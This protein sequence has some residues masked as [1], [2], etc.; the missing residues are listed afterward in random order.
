M[1][2]T[3][4]NTPK[5]SPRDVWGAELK[6]VLTEAGSSEPLVT[7]TVFDGSE[8]PADIVWW[9]AAGSPVIYIG[10]GTENAGSLP[11][12]FADLLTQTWGPGEVTPESPADIVEWALW[13]VRF[14]SGEEVTFFVSPDTTPAQA[15]S[16]LEI[17]MDI[18]L[19]LVIRF[20]QTQMALRD[21]A[22]LTP[23]SVIGFGRGVD[24]PV[25]LLV[26]GQLLARGEAVTVKG[27]YGIRI[28]E[29]SSRRERLVTSSLA[30]GKKTL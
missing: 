30:A 19:P 9:R 16:N 27:A 28:S 22:K 5:S 10:A 14:A 18:E 2:N 24:E 7:T 1:T 25:E 21:I 26:N 4:A 11:V 8:M 6:K 3:K 13:T 23:G 17:L 12:S 15:T 29:I 20:G